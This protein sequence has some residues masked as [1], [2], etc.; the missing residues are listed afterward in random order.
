MIAIFWSLQ[1]RQSFCQTIIALLMVVNVNARDILVL[2]N[3]EHGGAIYGTRS[4][5]ADY[6][7]LANDPNLKLPSSFTI[8]SSIKIRF[9]LT[10]KPF[11]VIWS[12]NLDSVVLNFV[13][14]FQRNTNSFLNNFLPLLDLNLA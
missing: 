4:D 7:T 10:A 2:D 8:C 5:M 12:E 14:R 9:L 6:V 13:V 3:F 1:H 11:F